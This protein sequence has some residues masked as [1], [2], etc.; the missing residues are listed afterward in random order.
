MK[1][2]EELKAANLPHASASVV[3]QTMPEGTVMRDHDP[4]DPLSLEDYAQRFTPGAGCPACGNT[5]IK[6]TLHHGTAMCTTAGCR[7]GCRVYHYL[8]LPDGTEKLVQNPLW[9]HPDVIR[10]D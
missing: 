7:W 2:L 3:F 10:E 9:Y 1:T 6:W 4:D 8:S 5:V